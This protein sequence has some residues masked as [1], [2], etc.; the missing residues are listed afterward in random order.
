MG[1]NTCTLYRIY[2]IGLFVYVFVCRPMYMYVNVCMCACMFVCKCECIHVC[3]CIYVHVC[4]V[5]YLSSY[6]ALLSAWAFQKR[7]RLQHWQWYCVGVNTPKCHRQ[8]Q[9]KALPNVL[10]WRLEWDSNMRPSGRKAPNPT[11]EP[12]RS[13][14]YLLPMYVYVCMYLCV[15]MHMF[16][17][18]CMTYVCIYA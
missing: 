16:V 9:V 17:Y 15:C 2:N 18:V 12:P 13:R 7:S 1:M 11:T 10:T 6:I 3:V 8:L 4:I 14:I 5:M